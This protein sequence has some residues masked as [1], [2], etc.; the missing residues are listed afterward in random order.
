MVD[1]VLVQIYPWLGK[2]LAQ[3]FEMMNIRWYQQLYLDCRSPTIFL[4]FAMRHL[5]APCQGAL[6]LKKPGTSHVKSVWHVGPLRR[7][8]IDRAY[9]VCHTF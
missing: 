1:T 8:P 2:W 9:Q 4:S 5:H 7:P 3:I 6:L